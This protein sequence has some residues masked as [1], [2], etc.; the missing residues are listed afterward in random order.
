MSGYKTHIITSFLVSLTTITILV[1]LDKI[2][3]NYF[4]YGLPIIIIYSILPDL[5]HENSIIRKL[6][7]IFG[8]LVIILYIICFFYYRNNIYLY[9]IIGISIFLLSLY[10]LTH[11]GLLHSILGS[12]L[13]SLPLLII[14]NYWFVILAFISYNTHLFIDGEI[15]LF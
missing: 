12:L 11:R 4:I 7:N 6:T 8:F 15:K 5:D 9:T 13:L 1:A 3:K 14:T 10:F 2:N